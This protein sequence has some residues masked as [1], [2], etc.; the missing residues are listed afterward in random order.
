MYA[1]P[2]MVEKNNVRLNSKSN[3][4]GFGRILKTVIKIANGLCKWGA[5]VYLVVRYH[6]RYHD[7]SSLNI[8]AKQNITCRK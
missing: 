3:K 6:G 7:Y 5:D 8:A 1:V 2:V 4:K